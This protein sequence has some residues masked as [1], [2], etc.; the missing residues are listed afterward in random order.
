MADPRPLAAV[1]VADPTPLTL[2]NLRRLSSWCDLLLAEASCTFQGQPRT[3]LRGAWRDLL[4][5]ESPQLRIFTTQL[6]AGSNAQRQRTQRN[7]VLPA[8]LREPADR[9]VLLADADEL[10]DGEM[11]RER[12]AAGIEA[13]V[14]LGLV[15]LYGAIDRVAPEIH[16]CWKPEWAALRQAPPSRPYLFVGPVL[17]TVAQLREQPASTLRYSTPLR[18]RE[19]AYGVHVTMA[20]PIPRVI[21]KLNTSRHTW[22]SRIRD[23]G[24]L[25]TMLSAGVHH[26]GWW[27]AAYREPEGWLLE[28]AKGTDLRVAGPAHTRSH[29]A[30]LRAWSE[31]RLDPELP[32]DLVSKL[33][34]YV[35]NRKP[36][37]EDFLTPLDAWLCTR[38]PQNWAQIDD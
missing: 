9:P 15:P 8:L 19:H 6:P 1:M 12:I 23:P 4:G 2:A 32:D 37:I 7:G 20:E 17:A 27:V 34:S 11:V 14:R 26:A 10:L 29:L 24:H 31:A 13:P 30:A 22:V 3:A 35:A 16:C 38:V 18:D 33:D 21:Q 25:E 36:G 28:L 5:L